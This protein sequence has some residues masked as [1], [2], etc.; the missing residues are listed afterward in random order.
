MGTPFSVHDAWVRKF[1]C[2]DAGMATACPM[3]LKPDAILPFRGISEEAQPRSAWEVGAR[4]VDV[5]I[6][7]DAQG[8]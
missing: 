1:I 5:H 2:V 6:D 4:S 8:R 7:I 3:T